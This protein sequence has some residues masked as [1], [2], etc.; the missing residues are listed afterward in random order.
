MSPPFFVHF[1]CEL[2]SS[3]LGALLTY[4]IKTSPSFVIYLHINASLN[5][6]GV[7]LPSESV[8]LLNSANTNFFASSI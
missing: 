4:F 1:L 5:V 8:N 3:G 6:S 7:Y 2:Y